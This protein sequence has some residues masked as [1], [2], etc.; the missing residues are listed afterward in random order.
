MTAVLEAYDVYAGYGGVPVLKGITLDVNAGEVVAL[1]G[2]NGAGKTTAILTLA[3]ELGTTSGEIRLLG[4]STTAPLYRRARKG[5]AL[6]PEER[7]IVRELSVRDNLR[8]GSGDVDAAWSAFP[9]LRALSERRAGLLSGGEQQMLS[10]ARA[11]ARRPKVL[12]VDELSFG[13]GPKVVVRLLGALHALSRSGVGILLVEQFV[14]RA[15]EFAD[16][17][18]ILDRGRI[19]YEGSGGDDEK[20][21]SHLKDVYLANG[22]GGGPALAGA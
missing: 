3:G 20:V 19:V 1:F 16:R 8:L 7:L 4:D 22:S 11:I 2:P 15:L 10:M 12:L 9:E 13:L 17:A 14:H 21:L 18:Y 6:V 5:L